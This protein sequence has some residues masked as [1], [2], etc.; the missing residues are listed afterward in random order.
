MSLPQLTDSEL[1]S[2]VGGVCIGGQTCV[3]VPISYV[4]CRANGCYTVSYTQQECFPCG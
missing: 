1:E 4:V 2:V 3:Y